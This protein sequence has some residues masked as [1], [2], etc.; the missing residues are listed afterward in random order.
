MA[1]LFLLSLR[2]D[3]N[4]HEMQF[5][6]DPPLKVLSSRRNATSLQVMGRCQG[7]AI[8]AFTHLHIYTL[9]LYAKRWRLV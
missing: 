5:Y 3:A 1:V 9:P 6:F 4:V 7:F 2:E 8:Y